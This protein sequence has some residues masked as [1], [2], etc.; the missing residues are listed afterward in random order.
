MR[1]EMLLMEAQLRHEEGRLGAER[2]RAITALR[3]RRW[4]RRVAA[5]RTTAAAL[6]GRLQPAPAPCCA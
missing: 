1:D 6:R 3:R 5:M 4:E 2:H